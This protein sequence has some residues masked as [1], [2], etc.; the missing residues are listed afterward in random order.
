MWGTD[1]RILHRDLISKLVQLFVETG[2]LAGRSFLLSRRMPVNKVSLFSLSPALA[3][4]TYV[5]LLFCH[6]SALNRMVPALLLGKIY[7]NSF[8]LALNSHANIALGR[9]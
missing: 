7:S 5:I 1:R 6:V 8:L 3:A 2:A 4:V 9:I